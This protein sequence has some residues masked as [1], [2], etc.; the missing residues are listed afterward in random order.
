[1]CGLGI[2]A[3]LALTPGCAARAASIMS[4]DEYA[5]VIHGVPYVLECSGGGGRLLLYGSAHLYD[6]LAPQLADI[7]QH[8]MRMRPTLALNEG[9]NP[10]VALTREDA[11]RRAG[12]AGLLRWLG[13]RD[14]VPVRTFEP[15][16]EQEAAALL[17]EFSAEQVKSF[18]VLRTLAQENVRPQGSPRRS[19]DAIVSGMLAWSEQAHGLTAAP[20]TVEEFVAGCGR[21]AP[22]LA[23]WRSPPLS[24]FDPAPR[25]GGVAR[26]TNLVSRRASELRDRFILDNVC[27]TLTPDTRVLAVIGASHVV[28]LEPALRARLRVSRIAPTTP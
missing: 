22:E 11:I 27:G 5:E 16:P 3:L 26:W 10:P 15:P 13:Q 20:R 28:M 8:W 25:P 14:G 17:T 7:E 21:L 9:G 18:Y 2:L 6:P 23:D 4:F 24:W 12:E 1:M 19:A